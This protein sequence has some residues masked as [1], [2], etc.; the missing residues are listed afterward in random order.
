[1]YRVFGLTGVV[2][3]TALATVAMAQQPVQPLVP[4]PA[5]Q[6]IIPSDPVVIKSGEVVTTPQAATPQV[7][8]TAPAGTTPPE[9]VATTVAQAAP[10]KPSPLGTYI[11]TTADKRVII[12]ETGYDI[13]MDV[14]GRRQ[15][16]IALLTDGLGSDQVYPPGTPA[17]FWPLQVG[18]EVTFNYGAGSPLHVTARVLRTETITVP[19]GTFFTYVVERRSHPS[20]D[21]SE[22]VSTFWYAPSVGAVVKQVNNSSATGS[23]GSFEAT[24]IV[25]P[26]PLNGI[27]VTIPGDTAAK[28][29]E[30]C[31]Q[32]GTTLAM[33]SGQSIP[34]PCITYV[35][36]NLAAYGA[37]LNGGEAASV[38]VTR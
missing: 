30:F 35:Q 32:R 31:A 34:V 10:Y 36:T 29:A 1:M 20:A 26:H 13:I 14:N 25:L 12:T 3:A 11:E 22:S 37:W 17:Q 4:T 23:R 8:T 2:C 28:R 38:P 15:T 19:A 6:H 24:S 16:S 9:Y 5:G 33:P 7:A 27:P 21:F 18:K